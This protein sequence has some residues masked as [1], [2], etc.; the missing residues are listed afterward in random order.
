MNN[1][2][3]IKK[4]RYHD[5]LYSI[6]WISLMVGAGLNLPS[7]SIYMNII[8]VFSALIA[9]L[10]VIN[11]VFTRRELFLCFLLIILGLLSV[12]FS[13]KFTVL[14][15]VL[16]ICAGKGIDFK[17][18]IK[19][20][21]WIRS[22]LMSGTILL[23]QLGI[24]NQYTIVVYRNGDL[25]TRSGLGLSHPNGAHVIFFV[26]IAMYVYSYYEKFNLFSV[27]TILILNLLMYYKTNSRTGFLIGILF[28]GVTLLFQSESEKDWLNFAKK[29]FLIFL[30]YSYILLPVISFIFA[31]MLNSPFRAFAR[32]LNSVLSNR[33]YLSYR[34]ILLYPFS[35]FG[36]YIG[37][38]FPLDNGFIRTYV[39]RGFIIFF[40]QMFFSTKLLVY[41]YSKR[42]YS[43]ILIMGF[44]AIYNLSESYFMNI[45]FNF[46]IL[47]LAELL[48]SNKKKLS[49]DVLKSKERSNEEVSDFAG[50]MHYSP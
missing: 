37:D 35:L 40:L 9:F 23:S 13:K 18:L 6:F 8:T 47:F 10:G 29:F 17:S 32:A 49:H 14:L 42:Q 43:K 38:G 27:L 41:F 36:T 44:F 26:V 20:S 25:I 5:V 12:V 16:A 3:Y 1:M 22:I 15:A 2:D 28:V 30:T 50:N 24:I 33:L 46:S 34:Y 7:T 39:E 4:D 21:F 31:F 48:F 19:I 11:T 45:T